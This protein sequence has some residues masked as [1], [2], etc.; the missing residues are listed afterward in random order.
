MY[1]PLCSLPFLISFLLAGIAVA[2]KQPMPSIS[3]PTSQCPQGDHIIAV[4]ATTEAQGFG[5][6]GWAV[7][8]L[9]QYNLSGADACSIVY[10]AEGITKTY[11]YISP[12]TYKTSEG[13]GVS[14]LTAEIVRFSE[15]CP[16]NNIILMGYSQVSETDRT[17]S[18]PTSTNPC[19]SRGLK[20][21]VT[22]SAG[23]WQPVIPCSG[24][25]WIPSLPITQRKVRSMS[26]RP[27]CSC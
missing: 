16:N 11:P 17:D 1:A 18:V 9:T 27:R 25:L 10:P 6:L 7:F 15:Q 2:E 23:A 20:S 5:V 4:R 22:C 24:Q 3:C 8:P 21:S 12:K 13:L 14:N 26:P 19:R